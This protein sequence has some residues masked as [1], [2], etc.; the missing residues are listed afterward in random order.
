MPPALTVLTL[1]QR[2]F[3][4]SVA[5][6]FGLLWLAMTGC[7]GESRSSPAGGGPSKSNP[8]L[9]QVETA[10]IQ[11]EPI[12]WP[13]LVRAQGTLV[14]DEQAVVG[15]KVPGR[16]AE[17]HV[18][19]GQSVKAGTELISLDREDLRLEIEQADAQLQQARAA[20]GLAVEAPLASLNP[21]S[22]PP[23]REAQAVLDE[24]RTKRAR[25]ERL[26]AQNAI[27]DTE[28]Q[29]AVA[30]EKVAAAQ[31]ASATNSVNEKIAL[32]YV[33][34]AELALARQ[35][36]TDAAMPAPF[37]GLV[38]ERHV[39]PGSYVQTGQAV[40]T[41]VRINPL[42]F[43]GTLPERYARDVR[44]GQEV[45]LLVNGDDIDRTARIN[46]ISPALD[47]ASRALLFEADIDNADGRLRAGLFGE[48]DVV[49]D[50][51]QTAL[52]V[53][54]SVLSEFAG[55][56]KVWKVVDGK[57]VEQRVQIGGRRGDLVEVL[58]GLQAGDRVLL[59]G[60]SGKPAR[61][62]VAST[63]TPEPHPDNRQSKQPS[64]PDTVATEPDSEAATTSAG[65]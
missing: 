3:L 40:V 9:P 12:V 63:Q 13:R 50:P 46:R 57:S 56:E 25:I 22:A 41:L 28:W 47:L 14:A 58:D 31:L 55:M 32:I 51:E 10:V 42:R 54:S 23:V 4:A 20:V 7:Q 24:A 33:R 45:H 18:D 30:A 64:Q 61:V 37:D 1:S 48:A 43:Q 8:P 29:Q 11:V 15:A 19:L 62:T 49:L 44:I 65:P 17:V 35:R 59:D 16:V 26:H 39:A 52:V 27:T 21:L 36:F 53:R 2:C 34:V 38:L 6:T 60:E 5:R